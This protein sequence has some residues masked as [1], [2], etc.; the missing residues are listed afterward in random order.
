M[1]LAITSL[2]NCAGKK[3]SKKIIMDYPEFMLQG[4]RGTRGLMPENTIP[5]MIKAVQD[6]A[7]VLEMDLQFTADGAV[8]VAHDPFINRLY[9]LDSQG[10]E[11]PEEDA[12]KHIIYA[13]NYEDVRSFDVGS[14]EYPSY[15]KQ[16]KLSTYI[17]KLSALIDSVEQFTRETQLN[18]IFYNL[19]IKAGTQGDNLWHP[20]PKELVCKLMSV[21][22]NANIENRYYISS[23]DIRQI[24]EL[25]AS[26]PEVPL[27]FLTADE[28]IPISQ[29]IKSIGFTPEIFSPYY[30]VVTRAMVLEARELGIKIV[31]WTVNEEEMMISLIN[32]GVDGIITDYPGVLY[33]LRKE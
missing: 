22:K 31:P 4:H 32:M 27:A 12:R 1:L 7:N 9:S 6:G 33:Q 19:E 13:M 28:H 25:R 23:F 26:Y 30:K 29:H 15:P 18:P 17:P 20:D 21:L 5:G 2:T 10:N 11:I 16:G 24:K 3:N 14:K 8:V